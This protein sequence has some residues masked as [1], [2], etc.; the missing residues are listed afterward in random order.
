M[1]HFY[2]DVVLTL[3]K[4]MIPC[5]GVGLVS[6]T[7]QDAT[8]IMVIVYVAYG[9]CA[10]VVSHSMLAFLKGR[11]SDPQYDKDIAKAVGK[12]VRNALHL[13]KQHPIHE[14]VPGLDRETSGWSP[15]KASQGEL[16]GRIEELQSSMESLKGYLQEKST[17]S[18][19]DAQFISQKLV[20]QDKQDVFNRFTENHEN[21][22]S[23]VSQKSVVNPQDAM[24][25]Q[26][27][28]ITELLSPP[29]AEAEVIGNSR[30]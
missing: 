30:V 23:G 28:L 16:D 5:M 27:K 6:G 7:N 10:L 15:E 2:S 13:P 14:L 1:R 26:S 25:E 24:A 20:P 9:N 18:V 11:A 4:I 22:M 21:L 12:F 3:C 19:E 29:Q 8:P 17:A